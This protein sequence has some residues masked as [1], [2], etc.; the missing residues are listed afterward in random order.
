MQQGWGCSRVIGS[1]RKV[2]PQQQR[3]PKQLALFVCDHMLLPAWAASRFSS[4]LI[5][6]CTVLCCLQ[7]EL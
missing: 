2:Q 1:R 5:M 4:P 6:R 3:A 7:G